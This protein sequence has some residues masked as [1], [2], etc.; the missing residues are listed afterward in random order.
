MFEFAIWGALAL[1]HLAGLVVA[2][3]A[4]LPRFR[5]LA[6]LAVIPI[7]VDLLLMT[8]QPMPESWVPLLPALVTLC[9]V[10]LGVIGGG[11]LA[12]LAL[13]LATRAI[14]GNHGGIVVLREQQQQEVLRG[15]TA[16]GYLERA[17]FIGGILLGY[18]EV[19]AALIA[20]KGLGR[21]SELREAEVRERFI[22]GTLV[23]LIWAAACGAIVVIGIG[24]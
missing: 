7:G 10:A 20:I 18:P 3:L 6:A 2:I 11:P 19:L 21:Y 24:G 9:V 22:I 13:R 12:A 15:G 17:A 23:S 4:T 16:I 1:L 5:R 8:F 14:P